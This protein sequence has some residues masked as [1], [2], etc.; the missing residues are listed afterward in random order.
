MPRE[1]GGGRRDEG[2]WGRD[3]GGGVRE[4]K[5]ISLRNLYNLLISG[6]INLRFY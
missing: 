4:D 3:E 2:R 5:E 1:E 6:S